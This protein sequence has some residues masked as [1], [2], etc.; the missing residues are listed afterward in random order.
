MAEEFIKGLGI[1]T[2][3]G[4]AWLVLAGW[5]R[6][7]SFESTQQLVAPV[8]VDLANTSVFNAIGVTLMDA[9]FWFTLFGALA[10]WVLIPAGR[11][12][13]SALRDRDADAE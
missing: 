11:Q 3:G 13:R 10:F 12:A 7:E 5:Y 4:L 6:T 1:F 8:S 2:G 9:F